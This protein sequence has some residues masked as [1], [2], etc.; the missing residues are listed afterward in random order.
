MQNQAIRSTL[1]AY[2]RSPLGVRRT[3]LSSIYIAVG[4]SD[5][6][7]VRSYTKQGTQVANYPKPEL[8]PNDSVLGPRDN[9]GVAVGVGGSVY[10]A[11]RAGNTTPPL[12]PRLYKYSKTGQL[13]WTVDKD[14]SLQGVRVDSDGSVYIVGASLQG[15]TSSGRV[16]IEKHNSSGDV[17]WQADDPYVYFDDLDLDSDGSLFVCG[18]RSYGGANT[19]AKLNGTTGSFIW[20]VED[21]GCYGHALAVDNNNDVYVAGADNFESGKFEFRGSV[22]KFNGTNGD[23]IFSRHFVTTE[24]LH[25]IAVDENLNYYVG[26][27]TVGLRKFNDAGELVWVVA[28]GERVRGVRYNSGLLYV[29]IESFLRVYDTDGI[30][31][32]ERST[33]R[34]ANAIAIKSQ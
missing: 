15:T 3:K 23:V 10:L 7:W 18:Y 4:V 8:D 27:G 30:L 28:D 22:W 20:T 9:R 26:G 19:V 17:V 21:I 24:T 12:A 14:Y 32:Y 6:S 11:A 33:T 13:V 5:D 29:V 1:G 31:V 2:T 25:A 16:S 34:Q